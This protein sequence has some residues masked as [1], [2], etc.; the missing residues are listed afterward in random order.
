MKMKAKIPVAIAAIGSEDGATMKVLPVGQIIIIDSV[1]EEIYFGREAHANCRAPLG[2]GAN[3]LF[4]LG[5][6][7]IKFAFEPIESKAYTK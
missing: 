3:Y 4:L 6:K 5:L 7:T 1:V 2:G